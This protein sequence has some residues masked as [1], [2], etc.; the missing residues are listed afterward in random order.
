MAFR[1]SSTSLM[2]VAGTGKSRWAAVSFS[3]ALLS[4][5]TMPL[6]FSASA[7]MFPVSLAICST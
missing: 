5:W 2:Q 4:D 6:P 7:T 1:A 3:A